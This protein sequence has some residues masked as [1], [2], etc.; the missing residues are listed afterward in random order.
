MDRIRRIIPQSYPLRSYYLSFGYVGLVCWILSTI[1]HTRD[2][3]LTE[4]LDYFGAAGNVL[5]GLYLG[6]IRI[7]RLYEPHGSRDS[8]RRIWA[9]LCTVLYIAH[10]SYLSFWRFDYT[11]NMVANVTVGTIHHVLWTWYSITRYRH[12][13]RTWTAWPSM[14]V[15]MVVFAM[16][17]ELLD[18]APFMYLI[19][20]HSL[21]H[22]FTVAPTVWWYRYV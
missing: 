5:Y 20:A 4:K 10:V 18:F 14:I 15:T 7:F 12:E 9:S 21:W 8:V 17:F 1:F 6:V 2:S 11:Y 22:L 16:S 3:L 19:D 13:L